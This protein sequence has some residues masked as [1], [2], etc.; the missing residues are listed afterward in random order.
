LCDTVESQATR[1]ESW[2]SQTKAV[3]APVTLEPLLLA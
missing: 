3:R 2:L 1:K